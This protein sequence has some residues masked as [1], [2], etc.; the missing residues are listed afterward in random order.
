MDQGRPQR[1]VGSRA[2]GPRRAWSFAASWC[3]ALLSVL[4]GALPA[5]A[6]E[7]ALTPEERH[8]VQQHPVVTFALPGPL[9][10]Y[11]SVDPTSGEPQG[12]AIEMATLVAERAGLR[13]AYQVYPTRAEALAAVVRGDADAVP[14]QPAAALAAQ[15]GLLPTRAMLS[16]N[17]VIAV[18]R[19][20]PDISPTGNFGGYRV[21]VESGSGSD[22]LLTTRF[23]GARTQRYDTAE[24]AMRA[25]A[26]GD[27]DLYLGD[28]RVAVHC[29]ETLLMANVQ[30]RGALGP[31]L[32]SIGPAVSKRLPLLHSV[33]DKALETIT[34]TERAQLAQRWL[35]RDT[36]VAGAAATVALTD[37]ERGWVNAHGRIRVGYDAVFAP[38]TVQ[39][40]LSQLQGLGA[41]FM[42]L[43]ADKVGLAIE[44]ESGGSFAEVYRSGI[45]GRIDVIVGA[46]RTSARRQH[47]DFVGPFM[48]VPT[49]IA[50]SSRGGLLLTSLDGLGSRQRLALLDEHFLIP[51]LRNRYPGVQLLTFPTQEAVLDAVASGRAEAAIG[52]LKV[53]NQLINDRYTGRVR[54]TG[55]VA[56]ADSELYFAVRREL[57]ELTRLLRKGLDAI[58][59]QEASEIERRWLTLAA[60]AGL[61]WEQVVQAGAVVLAVLVWLAAWAHLLRRGNRRL[62]AARQIENDARQLAEATTASRGRFLSYLTHELRGTLGA[63]AAG[64]TMVRSDPSPEQ[65]GRMLDAIQASAEGFQGLMEATLQYEQQLERPLQLHQ[66]AVDLQA[67]WAPML[68]PFELAAQA[69]GLTLATTLDGVSQDAPRVML[70]ATRWR[71][72][73][74][75]LVG[76]AIK[77]TREGTVGV[78]G[79]L[80]K[81]GGGLRFELRVTDSGPG[82]TAEDRAS[83]FQPY[84]QGEQGQRLRQ[85]AGLGLAITRQIV[86]AM[87]GTIDV[88]ESDGGGAC[89]TVMVPLPQA[90]EEGVPGPLAVA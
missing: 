45:E 16:S 51:Q 2:G 29:I 11:F 75:N 6:S 65:R 13:L 74:N 3:L 67:L 32:S 63:I 47:Y 59:P 26:S 81:A 5:V 72:V 57:P 8:W 9:P 19:D 61:P 22:D 35:P 46:A 24:S 64:A 28:R 55:T 54:V 41:D 79:R 53:I 37:A 43:S 36:S 78:H 31:G 86:D 39:T 20:V 76:N 87:G 4:L 48:R 90:Q 52:N 33:L 62:R 69:K 27:A 14:L 70:D 85:G 50:T 38:I 34:Q 25:V 66:A 60:P 30:V 1:S 40:D 7:L 12:Y 84:A 23:P 49:G 17:T 80:V 68:A 77:F 15:R 88:S 71:Q 21:A 73:M 44:S 56:D 18:R 58:S 83:L 10:P 42:R 89:F 82:I